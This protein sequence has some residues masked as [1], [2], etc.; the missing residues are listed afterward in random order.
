MEVVG[1]VGFA[2]VLDKYAEVSTGAYKYAE[3]SKGARHS[4]AAMLHIDGEYERRRAI[5]K[6][7]RFG[8]KNLVLADRVAEDW[9]LVRLEHQEVLGI[10]LPWHNVGGIELVPP[11][12]CTLTEALGRLGE[13]EGLYRKASPPFW[14]TIEVLEKTDLSPIFLSTSPIDAE[15]YAHVT[16]RS[17][18]IH[19]DGFHRLLAWGRSGRLDGVELEAYVARIPEG[20]IDEER[21]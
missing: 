4:L 8:A 19:L 12:G 5:R 20:R 9:I 3:A 14:E 16:T 21:V 1:R 11:A 17:G 13:L 2:E 18:L 15:D 6:N 7:D 10:V